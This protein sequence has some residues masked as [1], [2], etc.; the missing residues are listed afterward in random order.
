MTK[1]EMIELQSRFIDACEEKIRIQDEII[2]NQEKIIANTEKLA[3][4]ENIIDTIRY[5]EERFR[6]IEVL[7]EIVYDLNKFTNE[8]DHIQKLVEKHF[9][10]FGEQYN[11]ASA[12]QRMRKALEGYTN[13]LYGE[14]DVKVDLKPDAE[15]ARRMDIF[16][17]DNRMVETSFGALEEENIIVELKAPKV[18]LTKKVYRQIEDYMDY[19][20]RQPA[21][22]GVSRRWKFIAVCTEVDEDVKS[23]Y[24]TFEDR[25]KV[26]L[27]NQVENYE[28]YALTWDDVIKS[29]ELKYHPLLDRLKY[30]REQVANELM[31]DSDQKDGREKVEALTGAVLS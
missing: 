16:L 2:D 22:N 3:K 23:R 14:P 28:V 21:F 9:W 19:V 31:G 20:R 15:N 24:K 11:L 5:L 29:F 10:L 1:N 7:R 18:V 12:D 8:R 25:G 6:V 17:C 26:G 13:I 27:V 4:L 30:D